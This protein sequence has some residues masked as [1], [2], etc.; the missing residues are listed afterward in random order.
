ANYKCASRLRAEGASASPAVASAEAGG[1][2][3][4]GVMLRAQKTSDG[5]MK[6]VYLSLSDGDLAPYA[7]VIDAQGREV[8]RTRLSAAARAGGGGGGGN[9]ARAGAGGAAGGGGGARAANAPAANAP[10]AAGTQAAA[11]P[12]GGG[13]AG[14][15]GRGAAPSL[16][17]GEWNP[18]EIVLS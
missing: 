9:A 15:G 16:K 6:G 3:V 7:L 8:T 5:G 13:G 14:G 12:R 18:I 1:S 17:T 10:P 2:C 4:A 11:A